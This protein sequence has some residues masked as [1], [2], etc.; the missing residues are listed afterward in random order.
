MDH[1]NASQ[2]EIN[3]TDYGYGQLSNEGKRIRHINEAVS[4]Q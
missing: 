4:D 2:F 1:A 3:K